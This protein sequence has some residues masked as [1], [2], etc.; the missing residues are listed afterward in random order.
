MSKEKSQVLSPARSPH[1][2]GYLHNQ[3]SLK[4]RI[5]IHVWQV[6]R[7]IKRDSRDMGANTKFRYYPQH[8]FNLRYAGYQG[9]QYSEALEHGIEGIKSETRYW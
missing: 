3:T 9:T 4:M 1:S 7:S 6:W 2:R 5:H 8:I